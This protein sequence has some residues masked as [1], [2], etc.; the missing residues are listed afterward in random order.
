MNRS[1]AVMRLHLVNRF[2]VFAL[3]WAILAFIFLVNLTIWWIV[4][5]SVGADADREEV[6]S[7]LQYSGATFYIFVYMLVLGVQAVALT[8]PFALGYGTTRRDFWIGTSLHFVLLSVV[9]GAGMTLLAGLEEATNGWGMGGRMFTAVYFGGT[10]VSWWVRG[11]LFVAL[12]LFFFFVGAAIA[13]I[14]QR[15]R[16][17]GMLVFFGALT[18]LLLGAVALLTFGE[19]WPAFGEWFA[20]NGATGAIAWSLVPTALAALLGYAVLRRATPKN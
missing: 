15:W 19:N 17:N 4:M 5:S 6:Q 7:G 1:I 9:Y 16:V 10:E 18:V 3:P 11:L 2:S 14:Y 13:T 12:F 8:F 20:V